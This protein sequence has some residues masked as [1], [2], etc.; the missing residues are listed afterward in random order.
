M[1]ATVEAKARNE[2]LPL[3]CWYEDN[4]MSFSGEGSNRPGR[5]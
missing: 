3:H 4:L 2:V 5:S 1:V